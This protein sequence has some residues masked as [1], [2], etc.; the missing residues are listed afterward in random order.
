MAKKSDQPQGNL[1][2]VYPDA[3]SVALT[4]FAQSIQ[5][6]PSRHP[7]Q[8]DA[9]AFGYVLVFH[10]LTLTG[11]Q[12]CLQKDVGQNIHHIRSYLIPSTMCQIDQQSL[13]D[14]SL[15]EHSCLCQACILKLP[16]CSSC[17]G[18]QLPNQNLLGCRGL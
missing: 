12:C 18:F 4:L 9:A 16:N 7:I 3:S 8:D 6:N 14:P 2:P 15:V 17:G 10:G 13:H 5:D 1:D 11:L